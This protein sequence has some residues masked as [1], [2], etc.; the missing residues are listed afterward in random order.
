M[1]FR[2]EEQYNV[3]I[4]AGIDEAGRGCL[5]GPVVAACVVVDRNNL[6]SGINDS[7][8]LSTQKRE[9]LFDYITTNYSF[10]FAPINEKRIDQINILQATI[11]AC[12]ESSNLIKPTPNMFLVD[13]NMKFTDSRFVSIIK[14]DSLS[15]S[16]ASAS[17]VAKVTRDNIMTE[18][19]EQYP[20][21]NWKKNKGYGTK[22]HL[23]AIAKYGLCEYHRKSFK[24]R[25]I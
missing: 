4:I 3:P 5:A 13:G 21:Y 7:K 1:D 18:L 10:S 9:S 2:I 24:L 11:E 15:L 8:K 25:V 12:I 16:I 6:I 22:E 20:H 14:G 23:E 19:H 17:I